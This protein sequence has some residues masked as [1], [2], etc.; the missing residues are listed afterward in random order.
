LMKGRYI[1]V[2]DLEKRSKNIVIGRLV[3]LDLFGKSENAL[4]KFLD[5]GGI[6]YR[7]VGVFQD[8]DGDNEERIIYMPYTT[9]QMLDQG[10]DKIGQI[11]LTYNTNIGYAGAMAF[12]LSLQKYLK[13]K[14]NI[15]PDDQNAIYL[16]NMADIV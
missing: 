10:T 15:A 7:V 9:R 14:H 11:T 8:D 16:R 6:I 1:N 13:S 4:G 5:V 2:K 12:D 3:E